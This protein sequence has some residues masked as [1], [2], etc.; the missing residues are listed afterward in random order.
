MLNEEV[1]LLDE[2]NITIGTLDKSQVHTSTTPLHLAF[3]TYIFNQNNELLLTRR[4]LHK[5]AWP[6]IW[7]NSACGHPLPGESFKDAIARRVKYEL[8]MKVRRITLLSDSFSYQAIDAT[9]IMENEY[10]PVFAVESDASIS[11]ETK[12]VMDYRWVSLDTVKEVIRLM[13]YLFSP[14]MVLQLNQSDIING[15]HHFIDSQ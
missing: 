8:N 3:S 1:I 5:I 7:T 2:N 13:P 14:W 11:P 10:C 12:E 9:G 15:L 6:G 4:S